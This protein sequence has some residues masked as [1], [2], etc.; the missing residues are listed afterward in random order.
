MNAGE[1]PRGMLKIHFLLPA[2]SDPFH[3]QDRGDLK[4]EIDVV[5]CCDRGRLVY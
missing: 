5:S 3:K 2:S 1:L 4:P